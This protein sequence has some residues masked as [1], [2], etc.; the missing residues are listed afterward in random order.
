ME[1]RDPKAPA[2]GELAEAKASGSH[3][4]HDDLCQ[5]QELSDGAVEAINERYKPAYGLVVWSWL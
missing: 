1:S 2:K 5:T 3:G 4:E